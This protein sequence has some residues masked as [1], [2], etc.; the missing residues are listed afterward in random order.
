VPLLRFPDYRQLHADLAVE[1]RDDG[2]LT[3]TFTTEG[4]PHVV[5][6]SNHA[7]LAD[8][9]WAIATD[10]SNEVVIFTGA[11]GYWMHSIDISRI[12][13]V[14]KP[15]VWHSILTEARRTVLGFL[16]IPV[17]VIAAVPGPA[18][19]HGEYALTADTVLAAET[20]S[21]QD[22]QHLPFG[23]VPADG[24]QVLWAAAMGH[25]RAHHF[26]LSGQ[27]IDA[28]E[29][30]RLGIA[31]EIVS[32]DTL[33]PRAYEL[34]EQYLRIPPLTRRYTR[35]IFTRHLKRE[36]ND[37]IAFDMGLEGLSVYERAGS[38]VGD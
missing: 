37:H 32:D 30:H 33:L 27:I 34:A 4:G 35:L 3:V 7:A 8:L 5:T 38:S 6:G 11:G 19:I 28:H 29:A 1:R 15:W 22:N 9:L 17:P 36:A 14:A 16:E 21:F 24:A 25:H 13:D 18:H 20:A 26:L 31:H 23:V 10:P 2:V 12:E